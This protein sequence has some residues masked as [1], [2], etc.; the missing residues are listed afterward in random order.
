ML[1]PRKDYFE[2]R[3]FEIRKQRGD[4]MRILE[5]MREILKSDPEKGCRID[6]RIEW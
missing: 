1:L 5:R 6:Y 2:N 3:S 4:V